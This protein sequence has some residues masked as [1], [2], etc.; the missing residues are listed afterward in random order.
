MSEQGELKTYWAVCRTFSNR[1]HRVRQEIEKAGHGTFCPTYA[2]VWASDGK[3]SSRERVQYPG[4]LFFQTTA[5][6]W[7]DVRSI[8]GVDEVLAHG[9][10]ARPVQDEEMIRIV[11]AD[12]T[13][14]HN[15]VDY[16]GIPSQPRKRRRRRRARPGKRLRIAARV[17]V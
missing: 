3:F 10:I 5:K 17:G 9:E 6:G 2:R 15:E 8:D 13:Q 12:A 7:G 11:I 1:V 16:S 14:E 4:Y